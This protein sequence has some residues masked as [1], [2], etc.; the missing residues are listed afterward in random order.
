M[1]Q[2]RSSK[3]KAISESSNSSN[4]RRTIDKV[5][6]I[7]DDSHVLVNSEQ[8]W[9]GINVVRFH[10]TLK[11][12]SVPPFSSHLILITLEPSI[13]LTEKIDGHVYEKSLNMGDVTIVPAGLSSKWRWRGQ[14][15]ANNLQI[16]IKPTLLSKVA[17][18]AGDINPDR[19]EIVNRFGVCDPQVQYIG[20]A[21]LAEL[22]AGSRAGRLY[23]ESL[24]IALAVRLLEKY[25]VSKPFISQYSGGIPQHKL[26]LVTEY[27]RD[28]LD[29][30]LTLAEI[31][32]IV[33]MNPYHLIRTFKQATGVTPHQYL[34]RSRIERAQILLT[35]SNLPI[36]GISQQVGFKDQSHFTKVFRKL[37]GVTPKT[38]RNLS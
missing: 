30:K 16:Y 3:M 9:D 21:L 8:M 25:S 6:Q 24:G 29:R 4:R 18:E 35:K 36:V 37:T 17:A 20:F 2:S 26:R 1:S 15:E 31:S 34:R 7:I 11:E 28:N 38:Y 5:S 22:E 19:I 12:I 23:S 32:G 27:I 13:H 33:G 14:K 10:H